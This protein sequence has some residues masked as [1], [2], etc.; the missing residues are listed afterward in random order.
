M[1]HKALPSALYTTRNLK[2]GSIFV[3]EEHIMRVLISFILFVAAAAAGVSGQALDPE[4]I[5]GRDY[6]FER[7]EAKRKVRDAEDK[8]TIRLVAYVYR[9]LKNDRHEVVLFSHGSTAGMIRSPKEPG[10]APPPAVIRFF[11]SRGYTLV[12]PMR[13]GRGESSGTYVEECAFYLG[14]CTLAQQLALTDRSLREALLD[15]NAVIDQLILGR[16]VAR[17]S[18]ILIGGISRGGFLSLVLAGERPGLVKGVINF[19]GGWLSVSDQYSPTDNQQ[20]L[21]AQTVRLTRAAKQTGAPSIWIYAARDPFYTEVTTREFF[22]SWRET[23]AQAEYV[24]VADHSLPSGHGVAS[25]ATLWERQVDAFL[26]TIDQVK[27]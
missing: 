12:A 13:R 24:F 20:R 2:A 9:P 26:K 7:M 22:R 10:D 11:V 1:R 27:R 21:N 19:V 8:G 25:N 5:H 6:T 18:K 23:G 3:T 14:Q 17:Q 4:F 15:S 16:L